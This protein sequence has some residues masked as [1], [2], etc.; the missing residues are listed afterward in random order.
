MA[1]NDTMDLVFH[2][3]NEGNVLLWSKITLI[4]ERLRIA[5]EVAD[6]VFNPDGTGGIR[7]VVFY[8][9][10]SPSPGSIRIKLKVDFRWPDQRKQSLPVPHRP[11]G[12]KPWSEAERTSILLAIIAVALTD[13]GVAPKNLRIAR[14]IVAEALG[15]GGISRVP[16]EK[17]KPFTEA[18]DSLILNSA[19]AHCVAITATH[20]EQMIN[21]FRPQPGAP[22]DVSSATD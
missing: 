12:S 13:W 11:S 2:P 7:E 20:R 1:S 17:A 9:D 19:T 10:A 6:Q 18:L 21:L 8:L 5:L 4:V 22:G 3:E 16:R 15:P 14:E